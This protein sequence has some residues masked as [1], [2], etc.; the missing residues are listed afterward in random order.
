MPPVNPLLSQRENGLETEE[1]DSNVSE[2]QPSKPAT[3]FLLALNA[4][5]EIPWGFM[6]AKV[7][8]IYLFVPNFRA[9]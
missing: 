3:M 2:D 5:V 4:P 9:E 7:R 8:F 6:R 1:E